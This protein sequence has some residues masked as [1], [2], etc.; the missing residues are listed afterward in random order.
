M[1]RFLLVILIF[2]ACNGSA[3]NTVA[4]KD[5]MQ[6]SQ[7]IHTN[8]TDTVVTH[9]KPIVLNGCYQMILKKDTA[10][11]HLTVKDSTVTGEL[12]YDFYQKDDNSGTLKGVLRNDIIYADYTF[13]SE[14]KV[15]VRELA[16]KVR[17]RKL[18]QGF[19]NIKERNGKITFQ[20]LQQLQFQSENP[21]VKIACP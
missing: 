18:V 8:V 11:M 20:N 16:F 6:S 14:G 4:S 15:S 7:T 13:E 19:G 1:Y 3:S 17:D 5:T 12:Q 10:T 21:F 9:A 2:Y